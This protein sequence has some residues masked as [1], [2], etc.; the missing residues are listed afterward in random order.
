[1]G[2]LSAKDIYSGEEVNALK[3]DFVKWRS[4]DP[5]SNWLRG[6][7]IP[8]VRGGVWI[9]DQF[10]RLVDSLG[11]ITGHEECATI[12]GRNNLFLKELFL[13]KKNF[14]GDQR[15]VDRMVIPPTFDT[16]PVMDIHNH[17]TG[18][19]PWFSLKD[20]VF[21]VNSDLRAQAV[22]SDRGTIFAFKTKPIDGL[23]EIKIDD[24]YR[25][26]FEDVGIQ[27]VLGNQLFNR[28]LAAEAHIKLF[29]LP[30]G[31]RILKPIK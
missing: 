23:S 24:I 28:R 17:L 12:V 9:N 18:S 2:R 11:E 29:W 16:T 13:A 21:F 7:N 19:Q 3:N 8:G 26:A 10:S 30:K 5:I 31:N 4:D 15:S 22:V 20:N 6:I 14:V 25:R 1:M 27:E